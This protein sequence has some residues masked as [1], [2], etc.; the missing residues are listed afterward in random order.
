MR[1][2]VK[3]LLL[4]F[5][6]LDPRGRSRS[7]LAG[8]KLFQHGTDLCHVHGRDFPDDPQIH[9]GI[10]MGDDIAH[11]AHFSKGEF[12]DG[13]AA[14][15]SYVRRGLTDDFDSPVDGV[16]FLLVGAEFGFR[17]VFDVGAD[18]PGSFENVAKAAG[19]V[20]IQAHGGGQ[21]VLAGNAV[22]G[23]L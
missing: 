3:E 7:I 11:A 15:L 21:D 6:R 8:E 12:R 1:R 14:R 19:S 2:W 4:E 23:F 22:R 13:P 17:G 10:V 18:E 20:S 9:V 16:L 5:P